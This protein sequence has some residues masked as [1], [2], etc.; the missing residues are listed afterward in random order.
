[1]L[2]L[3]V[4]I[5]VWMSIPG[6]FIAIVFLIALM[7]TGRSLRSTRR[8]LTISKDL[9]WIIEEITS[10]SIRALE[11]LKSS[12]QVADSIVGIPEQ[13]KGHEENIGEAEEKVEEAEGRDTLAKTSALLLGSKFSRASGLSR[14]DSEYIDVPN[15]GIFSSLDTIELLRPHNGSA[16]LSLLWRSAFCLSIRRRLLCLISETG[17]SVC[18]LFLLLQFPVFASTSTQFALLRRLA[19]WTL[20]VVPMFTS[21][22]RI[23]LG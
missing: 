7:M 21:G 5:S 10:E 8:L 2:L 14:R 17:L 4:S 1:M 9:F 6:G 23:K 20:S 3:L 13:V 11:L 22:G 12:R 19:P 16:G 18:C 15:E